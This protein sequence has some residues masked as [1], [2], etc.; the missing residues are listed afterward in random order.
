MGVIERVRVRWVLTS[1]LHGS[2]LDVLE[3]QELIDVLM[4][5]GE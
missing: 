1:R 4:G 5:S 2:H 3:V